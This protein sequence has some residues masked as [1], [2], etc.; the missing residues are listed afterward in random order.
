MPRNPR[1][2]IARKMPFRKVFRAEKSPIVNQTFICG[3]IVLPNPV[4]RGQLGIIAVFARNIVARIVVLKPQIRFRTQLFADLYRK[5][6][7]VLRH[8]A[9]LMSCYSN[10]NNI[11]HA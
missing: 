1:E 10:A 6:H 2:A 7:V 9:R 11:I 5:I 4:Q 8:P 3:R